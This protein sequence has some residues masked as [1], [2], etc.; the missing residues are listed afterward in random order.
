MK[1]LHIDDI[2]LTKKLEDIG[3][4]GVLRLKLEMDIDSC[5]NCPLR[6]E[7]DMGVDYCDHPVLP[8]TYES[9]NIIDDVSPFGFPKL[10]PLRK[11]NKKND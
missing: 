3:K 1:K 5:W 6:K 10:C 8:D 4:N 7:P 2:G 9:R 11:E